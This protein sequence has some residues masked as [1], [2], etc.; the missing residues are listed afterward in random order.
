MKVT[1]V[2]KVVDEKDCK[3]MS[4]KDIKAVDR[5]NF[6]TVDSKNF[7]TDKEFVEKLIEADIETFRSLAN[8]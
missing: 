2:N 1:F 4:Q 6:V 8:K 5:K 3:T 7:K